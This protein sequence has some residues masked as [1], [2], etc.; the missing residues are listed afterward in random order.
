MKKRIAS[1][2]IASA[3]GLTLVACAGKGEVTETEQVQEDFA[4]ELDEEP[5]SELE[6]EELDMDED[7]AEELMRPVAASYE[8]LIN[9]HKTAFE[10][11]WEF[12]VLQGKGLSTLFV[13]YYANGIDSIGFNTDIDIDGDGQNEM[14]V[15]DITAMDDSMYVYK[16]LFA[17][18]T[19]EDG[20]VVPIE[21]GSERSS[22]YLVNLLDKPGEALNFVRE[23]SNSAFN[24][25]T[26]EYRLEDGELKLVQAIVYNSEYDEENPWYIS[27]DEDMNPENGTPITEQE[28][29]D[30]MESN[31]NNYF[32][33]VYKSASEVTN[34]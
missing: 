22:L 31:Q 33:P 2:F 13:Y 23:G 12:D 17:A 16:A 1:I 34:K 5:V 28:A 14:L 11:E 29:L 10:E 4:D 8:E 27:Y 3:I 30:I 20:Q 18:Y 9:L 21:F 7:D 26:A 6:E 32:C 15:G 19:M 24:S 25:A